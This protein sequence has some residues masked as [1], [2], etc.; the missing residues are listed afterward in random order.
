MGI[1]NRRL[2][3]HRLGF[4]SKYVM[5][6]IYKFINWLMADFFKKFFCKYIYLFKISYLMK[7]YFYLQILK[8]KSHIYDFKEKITVF[9]FNEAIQIKKT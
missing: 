1:A 5:Y 2:G 6:N 8:F 3:D 9:I 7:F 4:F